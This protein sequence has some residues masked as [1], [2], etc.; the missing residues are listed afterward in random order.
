MCLNLPFKAVHPK[1]ESIPQMKLSGKNIFLLNFLL[2]LSIKIQAQTC[3][4]PPAGSTVTQGSFTI[5]ENGKAPITVVGWANGNT[6]VN[7]CPSNVATN[8]RNTTVIPTGAAVYY[9]NQTLPTAMPTTGGTRFAN[10]NAAFVVP[11]TTPSKFVIMQTTR[12]NTGAVK[13]YAC[14][15]VEVLNIPRPEFNIASCAS[16][17]GTIEIPNSDANNQFNSLQVTW[18]SQNKTINKSQWSSGNHK[19]PLTFT[20][21][22]THL[23]QVSGTISGC[24]SV[25]SRSVVANGSGVNPITAT[26]LIAR[27]EVLS[28][29]QVGMFT[30]QTGIVEV[31]QRKIADANYTLN[32]EVSSTSFTLFSIPANNAVS[33]EQYCFKVRTR[34]SCGSVSPFSVDNCTIPITV[35]A[36][37]K[38]NVVTWKNAPNYNSIQ[39]LGTNGAGSSPA[40][41]NTSPTQ[42]TDGNKTCLKYTYQV[43]AVNL[44]NGAFSFSYKQDVDG[45]D[46]TKPTMITNAFL[47]VNNLNKVEI[48]AT[49]PSAPKNVTFYRM[50]NNTNLSIDAP[51]TSQNIP[52]PQSEPSQRQECYQITYKNNCLVES[53]KSDQ[54]CAVFLKPTG[55]GVEWTDYKKFQTGLARYEIEKKNGTNFTL[56]RSV[57]TALKYDP[58]PSEVDPA[59]GDVTYRIK[60]VPVGGG[61]ASYSNETVFAPKATVFIAEAFT[62]NG[63]TINDTFDVNGYFIK[64]FSINI[65]NRWGT[66]IWNS[67]QLGN[68]KGWNGKVNGEDAP[69]GTYLYEYSM[70]DLKGKSTKRTGYFIMMR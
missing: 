13:T 38:Q 5:T 68:S 52:D 28:D 42:F 9:Y 41:N 64:E 22:G 3:P 58:D 1:K 54:F 53:D 66:P 46:D 23:V 62:P 21:T 44:V 17:Q 55:S 15:V 32:K 43:R 26:P 7:I 63:D 61:T 49:F 67:N 51:S 47:T 20:S 19:E 27:L 11:V 30:N 35:K 48:R 12:D 34:N 50:S 40:L 2:I 60:A 4:A 18:N 33:Q 56:V 31:H 8:V 39:V 14:Q 45:K 10:A 65:Y 70:A 29:T 59:S 36:E 16:G 24:P 57:G 69:M 37:N 25:N 6:V